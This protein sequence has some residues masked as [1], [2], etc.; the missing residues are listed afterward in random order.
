MRSRTARLFTAI[1]DISSGCRCLSLWGAS[2]ELTAAAAAAAAAAVAEAS[3]PVPGPPESEV[4]DGDGSAAAPAPA[5]APA[6]STPLSLLGLVGWAGA[7][8]RV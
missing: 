2:G 4:A 6:A 5:P 8:Q 3:T 7:T 1:S